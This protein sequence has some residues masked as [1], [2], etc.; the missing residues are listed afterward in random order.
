MYAWV[1]SLPGAERAS[2]ADEASG[3][4][5]ASHRSFPAGDEETERAIAQRVS[6][7][8]AVNFLKAPS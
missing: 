4:D 5:G 7:S 2:Q 6:R 8:E 1:A 3:K